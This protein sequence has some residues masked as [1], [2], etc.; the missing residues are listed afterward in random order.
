MN[1]IDLN[2][3]AIPGEM[4]SHIVHSDRQIYSGN[5]SI[6]QLLAAYE[7]IRG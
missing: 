3:S 5:K 7:V 1:D 6:G 2:I 4:K